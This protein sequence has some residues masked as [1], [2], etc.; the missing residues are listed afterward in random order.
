MKTKRIWAWI[1]CIAMLTTLMPSVTF[2]SAS[3]TVQIEKSDG[4]LSDKYASLTA[5]AAAAEEGETTKATEDWLNTAGNELYVGGV[6]VTAENAANITG[7]GITAGSAYFKVEDSVPTLY[8]DGVTIEKGN[9]VEFYAGWDHLY[10]IYYKPAS[11]DSLKIC[12][13][14]RNMI[15]VSTKYNDTDKTFGI[16]ADDCT[17]LNFVGKGD[18]YLGVTAEQKLISQTIGSIS[19]YG[20]EYDLLSE[21]GSQVS[22]EALYCVGDLTI[23]NAKVTA[24]AKADR[25]IW[26]IT[27]DDSDRTLI[28]NSTVN[29]TGGVDSAC[30]LSSGD[31]SIEN[32]VVNA[33]GDKNGIICD[34]GKS[35]TISGADTVVTAKSLAE[36]DE[37]SW[38]YDYA[39]ILT[40]KGHYDYEIPEITLNDG[41]EVTTPEAG[42][43]SKYNFP[44]WGAT[45]HRTVVDQ[46]GAYAREVV[47]K[48]PTEHCIC[49]KT[50]CTS[51]T[52]TIAHI[53]DNSLNLV[54]DVENGVTL[55][56]GSYYLSDDLE[57]YGDNISKDPDGI[58]YDKKLT[59]SGNV[60][61]CL[62]GHNLEA[63]IVPGK[64]AVLNICDCKG[65]GTITNSDAHAIAFRNDGATVSIYGGTLE[66]TCEANTIIDFEGHT[67][68]VL[69]LY[70]GTVKYEG[71]DNCTTLGSRTLIVNL[72]GGKVIATAANGIVVQN[73][74]V[75]LLGN[76][77]ISVSEGYNSIKVYGKELIDADGY[78]GGNISILCSGL[79]DGD[80]VVKNVTDET[81]GKFIISGSDSKHVLKRDGNNL[82]YTEVYTVYFNPNGGSGTMASVSGIRGEYELPEC[83]FTP[84]AGKKFK[85]W[86][87]DGR[88][89]QP[90]D[91]VN[92][93]GNTTIVAGWA[94]IE[95]TPVQVAEVPQ[96]FEY[97]S[98]AKSFAITANVTGGFIVTYK[99]DGAV[100]ASP[101]DAGAYDVVIKRDAD[102]IYAAYDKTIRRGLVIN[103]MDITGRATVGDFDE[104]TYT[105]KEQTPN[106]EVKIGSL[107]ITGSWSNVTNVADKTTFTA[108]GNFTG[109]IAVQDTNMK[110]AL[111]TFTKAPMA[112]SD[113]FYNGSAQALLE[114]APE[115]SGGTMKYSIDNKVTWQEEL[116]KGINA[117]RYEV[118]YKAF[119]D[120]NYDDSDFGLCNASIARASVDIPSVAGK[121]YTGEPL[122]ADISSN[123]YYTVSENNGGTATGSYDVKL[124]LKD[125]A[126][127]CWKDKAEDVSEVI[128]AFNISAAE[129]KWTLDP[130]IAGWMY[131]ENANSPSY[132]A[133]FGE[134]IIEYKKADEADSAYTKAIP[135]NAGDYKVRLSVAATE[136]YNGLTK[137]LD[138]SIAKAP[139]STPASVA[140]EN[141]SIC[142]KGDGKITGTDSMMEYKDEGASE[143]TAVTGNE[144]LNLLPGT[145][146]VRFKETENYLAG[147]DKTVV[148][149]A[150]EMITVAF[151]SNG[152]T[153]VD[154]KT[155][156]YNRTISTPGEPTK[157]G[158]EFAGWFADSGLT[159]EWNFDTDKFTEN[160]TL[161]AK[162]VQ[163]TISKD[164]GN[165]DEVAADGLNE[166]AKA[167]KTDI[168]LV[169]Q[170]QQAAEDN[171]SQIAIRDIA[172]APKNFGFYDIALKKSTGGTI[173]EAPG[174]IEIKLPYDFTRKTNIK[175]YRYHDANAQEL[176]QLTERDTVKPF[177]DGTCFIDTENRC[178]YI[179]SSKFSTYSVAY[180]TISSNS[181]SS[182]TAR[183]TVRFETNGAGSINS[184]TVI[185]NNTVREP[186]EPKKDG[187]IFDGWYLSDD[188]SEKYDFSSKVKKNLTL[189]AKWTEDTEPAKDRDENKDTTD[190]IGKDKPNDADTHD[191]PSKEFNDLDTNLWY[192]FA[193]DYVLSSGLMK[194]TAEKIFAPNGDLTRAML[195][196]I[197]YRNEGEPAVNENSSFTDIEKNA[198]YEN[199]VSWAQQNAIVKGISE[200]EFA[201]KAPITREQIAAMMHRY[202]E[203]KGI[204]VSVGEDTNILS[205]SDFDMVSE[206]AVAPLQWAAGLGLI[207]GR[208]ETT[209]N[210]KD[211]ATRAEVAAILHQFLKSNQ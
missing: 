75:N 197:L 93:S 195:V 44:G 135:S 146:K 18:A 132:G 168:S 100:I 167:E 111:I 92:I 134:V 127:Y 61:I 30:I 67:G 109:T 62:N 65:G 150:G 87:V 12:F 97:D 107:T 106:A 4:T 77:E 22:S 43:I 202:A 53:A 169:V 78:T 192:H 82:V 103:P 141:E 104:M 119:G 19:L 41:L 131:G 64:N 201:P 48:A 137:V 70:G 124:T 153:A 80:V 23:E 125:S 13:S 171:E 158:Y 91:M 133:K 49:G 15:N 204:D 210:P 6:A 128:I 175:V 176:T 123:E 112:K 203:F 136:N 2:A 205:Y 86:G 79:S 39:A 31:L 129:N 189:Y 173:S 121:V 51:H 113:L 7:D 1:L 24:V 194:G 191:C 20:G 165:I 170:V 161:Y 88:S 10:G 60:N 9:A 120:D 69:N 85:A 66:T 166:I 139:Q 28:K 181:G 142:G 172:D 118:Y 154:S 21:N 14:G 25:A 151:E 114:T 84:P 156:E 155:C 54:S 59:I 55:T 98:F 185:K 179:Y 5:A 182:S 145:Y 32:S 71:N 144:I 148:I 99:K 17:D 40:S 174:V 102:D 198:Y 188:F 74:K 52:G 152:G 29:L 73:G 115:A 138:L 196:A 11:D 72:Y 83:T 3:E 116:P 76:T 50:D 105:G 89:Y 35:I 164:E 8:L 16:Y 206:Y 211:N 186:N 36:I 81:A 26:M 178:I 177:D 108:N 159:T 207:K 163:G 68:N 147:E 122:T 183:Y 38:E 180:D 193:T 94:N 42:R 33:V 58:V 110:K 126:N 162:W 187:Y 45:E 101:T 34:D 157:E 90:G 200:T 184:Q 130:I 117:G 63:Q 209:L 143:Y 199:A 96:S 37:S 47:I 208:T 160:K 190:D 46:S 149:A 140:A 95:K 56:S 57:I 27:N